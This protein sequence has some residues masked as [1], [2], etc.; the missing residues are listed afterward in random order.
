LGLIAVAALLL[1]LLS[2]HI[3]SYDGRLA[4]FPKQG[5]TFADTVVD[6]DQVIAQY[7]TR[8]LVERLRGEGVNEYLI[9]KLENKGFISTESRVPSFSEPDGLT[10][11]TSPPPPKVTMAE[12]NRVIEGMSYDK[13]VQV[14]G[15]R[16]VELSSSD[17]AGFRSVM[18]Q[19][20]NSDGSGMT[21]MFQNEVLL[22]KS[23]YGLP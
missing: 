5:L 11:P 2:F 15:A 8:S 17:F 16:G 4:V 19:W 22:S 10:S 20:T 3:V 1:F 23:Q 13:V 6:V 21:A 7:N 18:Y 9:N 12:Y 14:V